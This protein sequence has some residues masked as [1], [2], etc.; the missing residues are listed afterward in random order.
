MTLQV[1]RGENESRRSP[2]LREGNNEKWSSY[3]SRGERETET[4]RDHC[5]EVR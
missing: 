3:A 2:E 5:G 1:I 4:L